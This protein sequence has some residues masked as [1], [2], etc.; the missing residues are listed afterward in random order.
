MNQ[1][2]SLL[3]LSTALLLTACAFP[4]VDTARLPVE[5]LATAP[6]PGYAGS[7]RQ[8]EISVDQTQW[9]WLETQTPVG[10]LTPPAGRAHVL[11]FVP[12]AEMRV[13]ADCNTGRANYTESL[14][15]KQL[16]FGPIALTRKL[17]APGSVDARWLQQLAAVRIAFELDGRLYLDTFADGGTLAF[18]PMNPVELQCGNDT[19][20]AGV[21][22]DPQVQR[23]W[24]WLRGR[25][26]VLEGRAAASGALFEGPGVSLHFKGNEAQ[27]DLGTG[28]QGCQVR[29]SLG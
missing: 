20:V 21:G 10:A 17:C 28:A 13:Y 6:A 11:H 19:L 1:P 14:P 26:Q 22:T 3:A 24:I 5:P 7:E 25:A 8:R 27:L 12:G 15:A 2:L 9:L 4:Q 23:A 29:A 16:E 18:L